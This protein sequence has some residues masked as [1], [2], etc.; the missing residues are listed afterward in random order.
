[1]TRIIR[2]M[3]ENKMRDVIF[4]WIIWR[5]IER[6]SCKLY[7]SLEESTSLELPVIK[8]VCHL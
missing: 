7:P 4:Y 1:M 8:I 3:K 2:E 5:A 6:E